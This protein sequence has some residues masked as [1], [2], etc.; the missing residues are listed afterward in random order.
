MEVEVEEEGFKLFF[1]VLV[2]VSFCLFLCF[3][4]RFAED[5]EAGGSTHPREVCILSR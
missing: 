4:F 5:E 1:E 2:F 3:G